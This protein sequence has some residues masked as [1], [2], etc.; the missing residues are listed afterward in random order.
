MIGSGS[1][2]P[3][4]ASLPC[5]TTDRVMTDRVMTKSYEKLRL[6]INTWSCNTN[7]IKISLFFMYLFK[8][9]IHKN[10]LLFKVHKHRNRVMMKSSFGY[11]ILAKFFNEKGKLF[12]SFL[13]KQQQSIQTAVTFLLT[14]A[15]WL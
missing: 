1:H 11:M 15:A 3:V 8:I 5:I 10:L 6:L 7:I 9:D 4:V 12:M 14:P 13:S 2:Y